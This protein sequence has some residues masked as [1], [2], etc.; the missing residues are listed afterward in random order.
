MPD[1]SLKIRLFV[2]APLRTAA[3]V[4]LDAAQSHYLAA[5]MRLRA[6]E[7]IALFNGRDG[8]WACRIASLG[9]KRCEVEVLRQLRPQ[10]PAADVWLLFA[11]VKRLAIDTLAAKAT[12][13]GVS[14]LQPVFTERSNVARINAQR[15]RANLIEAAEQCR[16]LEVPELIEPAHLAQALADW[17]V[18]RRLFFCD[19]S[20]GGEPAAAAMGKSP[21]GPAAILVGPEGGFS[22]AEARAIRALPS[23]TAISLGPRILRADTAALAGL[24]LWQALRGDWA[25]ERG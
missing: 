7:E 18:E 6:G 23:A 21:S 4:A 12:E 20:G 15:L 16:R 3:A 9:K 14:R 10:R 22:A 13:L 2:D 25:N 1:P 5:V 11:P 24:A 17:P 8:E 19:E